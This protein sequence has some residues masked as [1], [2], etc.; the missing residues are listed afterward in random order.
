MRP[1][2]LLKI[3]LGFLLA[4]LGSAQGL[5]FPPELR[6]LLTS[7]SNSTASNTSNSTTPSSPFISTTATNPQSTLS[8]D[9]AQALS[10]L[11]ADRHDFSRYNSHFDSVPKV[12]A[13]EQDY[14]ENSVLVEGLPFYIIGAVIMFIGLLFCIFRY[15]FGICGGRKS[16]AVISITRFA[17][18]CTLAM[19]G[20]GLTL[21]FCGAIVAI[22]GACK[23]R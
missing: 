8:R 18:N 11:I 13:P 23:Y 2:P 3:P 15:G 7:G 22:V 21:W 4:L 20:V 9:D 16:K 6:S 17:R 12:F 5:V 19:A 10:D 14:Y 1:S